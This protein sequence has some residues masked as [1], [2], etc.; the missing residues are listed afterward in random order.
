[1]IEHK[2]KARYNNY[3]IPFIKLVRCF[4]KLGAKEIT[5]QPIPKIIGFSTDSKEVIKK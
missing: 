4:E 1:M 2:Y 3:G 5:R